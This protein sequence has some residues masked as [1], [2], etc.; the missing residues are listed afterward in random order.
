MT[1]ELPKAELDVLAALWRRGSATARELREDLAELRPLA[2]ST[3]VTLLT[4][5]EKRALVVKAKG[6]TG[7]AFVYRA[8]RAPEK[9]QGGLVRDLLDRA[10]HGSGVAL[11]ASLFEAKPPTQSE[12]RELQKLLDSLGPNVRRKRSGPAK[13]SGKDVVEP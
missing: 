2:H 3:V 6:E 11:V 12:V 10:F 1:S 4:R 8:K 5:L 9:T 7:K 13:D